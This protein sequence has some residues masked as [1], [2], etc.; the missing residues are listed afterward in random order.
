V[1]KGRGAATKARP[2]RN[3]TKIPCRECACHD[4]LSLGFIDS[5]D[6]RSWLWRDEISFPLPYGDS[7]IASGIVD[8]NPA[9]TPM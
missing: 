1:K 9:N 3:P 5:G 2:A 8:R 7:D 6:W 4:M